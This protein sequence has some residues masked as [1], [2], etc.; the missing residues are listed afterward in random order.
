MELQN[1]LYE[2]QEQ[3]AFITLNRPKVLNALNYRTMDEL[4]YAF[5]D[6]AT[7]ESVRV[8]ILT[9]SGDKAFAAGADIDHKI[10]LFRHW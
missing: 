2:K 9:G 5:G 3:T 8:V 1:I 6:A 10:G 4:A 7:D